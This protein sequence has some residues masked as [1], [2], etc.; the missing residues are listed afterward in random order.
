MGSPECRFSPI[1][2]FL[3]QLRPCIE[4]QMLV[5]FV[6]LQ[7]ND[8]IIEVGS[9]NGYITLHLAIK[10]PKVKEIIG[11]DIIPEVVEEAYTQLKRFHDTFDEVTASVKFMNLDISSLIMIAQKYDSMISNPPFFSSGAS[12]VSPNQIRSTARIDKLFTINDLLLTGQSILKNYG[13]LY[14]VFPTK[15]IPEIEASTSRY[16]YKFITIETYST[17]RKRDGGISLIHLVKQNS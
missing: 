5:D 10:F 16:G 8:K 6:Q 4:S 1:R 17:V 9:G 12:R 13:S 15:R 2:L 14:L 7:P 3:D 11:I